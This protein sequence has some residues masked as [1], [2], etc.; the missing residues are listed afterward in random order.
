MEVT[1]INIY[2]IL[3]NFATP[4]FWNWCMMSGK[5]ECTSVRKIEQHSIT[6]LRERERERERERGLVR[7]FFVLQVPIRSLNLNFL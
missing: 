3:Q 2:S 7:F 1:S 5:S 6:H 4:K